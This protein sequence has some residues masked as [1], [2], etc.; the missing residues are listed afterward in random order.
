MKGSAIK[1][2][3]KIK[4]K[5]KLE[6]K[7]KKISPKFDFGGQKHAKKSIL[8]AKKAILEATEAILEGVHHDKPR[9]TVY[10]VSF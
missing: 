1:K 3:A 6:A 5:S 7:E 10:H 4:K 9:Q 8:E 2:Q